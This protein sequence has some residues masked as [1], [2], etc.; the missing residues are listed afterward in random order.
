MATVL[1]LRHGLTALTGPVLAG[2]TP[3]VHL[4]ERGQKQAAAV[5]ERIAALP[6]TAIV[7]SP[8][9]RCVETAEAIAARSAQPAATRVARR[10]PAHRVRLRRLDRPADQGAGQGPAVEGGAGAAV[11]GALPGRRGAGRDGGAGGARAV[12]DWDAPSSAPTRSGWPAA[13]A[14]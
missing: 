1:L 7:T 8:L 9:E 2:R 14:T 11:G 10:R 5:A 12:R 3:G 13:T 4:D 6:L